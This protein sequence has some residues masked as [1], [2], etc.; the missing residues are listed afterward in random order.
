[1]ISRRTT[2]ILAK[3]YND[4]FVHAYHERIGMG[5]RAGQTYQRHRVDG[6]AMYDFLFGHDYE[7][8][9]CN[10]PKELLGSS[11]RASDPRAVKDL[12]MKLHTG[13]TQASATTEWT[14]KQRQ[15]LGQMLLEEL[16]GDILPEVQNIDAGKELLRSLELDG[17]TYRDSRLLS[18]E[19]DVLDVQ[20]ETG[21]LQSL[22]KSLGL[23]DEQVVL[24]HLALSEAHYLAGRWDDSIS[25]S[26]KFLEGVLRE[27]ANTHS[28][29]K[30]NAPLSS[31]VYTSPVGV[32]DYLQS[33]GLLE[34]KEKQALSAV[35]GLL[36]NTGGHP[37]MAQN[38]QARLLRHMALTFSQFVML[39]LQ[40]SLNQP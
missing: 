39:R 19:S 1:M 2:G 14:W 20:E 31:T 5:P 26:R 18:P 16:A 33:E 22:Y 38:E 13:E 24:H 35:Y 29:R 11:V 3:V 28:T 12:I 9:F 36:S 32:R 30:K 4:K 7:A 40:G 34:A 21:V 23:N 17:Y 15:Q 8:W 6:N 25:N 10:K 37:Y 27:V